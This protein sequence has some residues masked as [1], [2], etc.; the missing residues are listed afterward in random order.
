MSSCIH[1]LVAMLVIAPLGAKAA[2]LVVWWEQ[3]YNPEENAAV[4]ETIAA[5]EQGSGKQVELVFYDQWELPERLKPAL[6]A[7]QPPDFAFGTSIALR[8]TEWTPGEQ[9]VN[10]TD[11]VGFF[12]DMFDQDA[13]PFGHCSTPRPSS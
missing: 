6:N 1:V 11:A 3:G 5:F 9:L 10:L 4:R 12:S 2:D 13:S 7:G 8:I